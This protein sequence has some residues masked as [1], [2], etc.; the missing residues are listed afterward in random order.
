MNSIIQ[1]ERTVCFL[2]GANSNL[3]PL[4]EHH[5]FGGPYRKLSE[6]YGLKVYLHHSKCHIYG[7]KSAHVNGETAHKLKAFAQKYA[8][9]E[10]GWS[11]SEFIKIFG[12]SY[13]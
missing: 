10:Y 13:I 9:M 7:E 2:C 5:V 6:R 12:Q 11:V 8:M 1:P 4:D 3:E